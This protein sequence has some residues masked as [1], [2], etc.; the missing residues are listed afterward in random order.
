LFE[1]VENL[2][3]SG[4]GELALLGNQV[5]FESNVFDLLVW[6]DCGFLEVEG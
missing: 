6:F 3:L 1:E 5:Q 4:V 2:L